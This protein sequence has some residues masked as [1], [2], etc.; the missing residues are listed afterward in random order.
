MMGVERSRMTLAIAAVGAGIAGGAALPTAADAALVSVEGRTLTYVAAPGEVN[1]VDVTRFI[2]PYA[3]GYNVFED[4]A[5]LR[6]GPGCRLA[7]RRQAICLAPVAALRAELG[8]GSD[9]FTSQRVELRATVL[10]GDG[11][12]LIETGSAPDTID[13]GPGDDTVIGRDGDDTVTG[14][15]GGDLL[16]GGDGADDLDGQGG[17][18]VAYGQVG[19]GDALFGG[20]GRDL[21]LG[22]GGR[23]TLEGEAGADAL[24]GGGGIDRLEG[25]AGNDQLTDTDASTGVVNCG[26]GDD[27]VRV[28]GDVNLVGCGGAGRA[29]ANTPA[30]WPPPQAATAAQVPSRKPRV[31]VLPRRRGRAQYVSM[32]VV[33]K[34][35]YSVTVRVRFYSRT[36]RY[37][38]IRTYKATTARNPRNVYSPRPPRGAYSARG[39]C[40]Y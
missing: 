38:G 32:R 20:L 18:D 1:V 9:M 21:L 29:S 16:L 36:T 10:G 34:Y 15:D 6:A 25:G 31:L 23:D 8:D 24:F 5:S 28:R 3:D 40:C 17:D 37:V 26:S 12:D 30:V 27:D 14:A 7:S 22:G 35:F 2:S 39:R 33:D 4:S 19:S 13:A 11:T